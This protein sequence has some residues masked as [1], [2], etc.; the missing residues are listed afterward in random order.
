MPKQKDLGLEALQLV[1]KLLA[2]WPGGV[3]PALYL[4]GPWGHRTIKIGAT[5]STTHC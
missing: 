3:A 4:L 2:L 5:A 1:M